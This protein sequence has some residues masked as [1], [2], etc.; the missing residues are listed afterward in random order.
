MVTRHHEEIHILNK[1]ILNESYRVG[2]Y[3]G[4]N[5]RHLTCVEIVRLSN[6]RNGRGILL[7]TKFEYIFNQIPYSIYVSLCRSIINPCMIA[8]TNA[9]VVTTYVSLHLLNTDYWNSAHSFQCC[10]NFDNLKM[11]FL[12]KWDIQ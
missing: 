6:D 10:H 5:R 2:L 8:D 1:L 11:I 3:M 9:L 7:V 4:Y 12:L